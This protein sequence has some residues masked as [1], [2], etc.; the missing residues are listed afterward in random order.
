MEDSSA[1]DLLEE[2]YRDLNPEKL[3]QAV[4]LGANLNLFCD[5]T[6]FGIFTVLEPFSIEPELPYSEENQKPWFDYKDKVKVMINVA[7]DN[8]LTIN[9]CVDEEGCVYYP[10]AS[11]LQYSPDDLEFVDWLIERGFDP[12]ARYSDA[13]QF[14]E[15]IWGLENDINEES[16]DHCR[17]LVKLSKH[18]ME[19]FPALHLQYD[20]NRLL[21]M[22]KKLR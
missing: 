5:E 2:A 18:L 15:L 6:P 7:L 17:W 12:V 11:F 20:F 1:Y 10:I 13:S 9:E 22:E 19:Y 4:A 21:E 14:E 3:K 16:N 8:G